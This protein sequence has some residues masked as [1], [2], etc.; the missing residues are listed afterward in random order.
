MVMK[1]GAVLAMT[2]CAIGLVLFPLGGRL[3]GAVLFQTAAYDSLTLVLI[4]GLLL[5][6]ALLASYL[7]AR[8]ASE[9]DPMVALRRQ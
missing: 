8:R 7:P 9:L 1:R 3:V 2:G 5:G 4:P 6:L